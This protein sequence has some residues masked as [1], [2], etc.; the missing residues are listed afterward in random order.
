MAGL[1]S[2]YGRVCSITSGWEYLDRYLR[3][4]GRVQISSG[5]L[6]SLWYPIDHSFHREVGERNL[7][8]LAEIFSNIPLQSSQNRVRLSCMFEAARSRFWGSSLF[9][10]AEPPCILRKLFLLEFEKLIVLSVAGY[11]KGK[12]DFPLDYFE[13]FIENSPV[14]N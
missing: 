9:T 13:N 3:Y 5:I 4:P 14:R 10:K 6:F 7:L 12:T 11:R 1:I 8:G 2:L